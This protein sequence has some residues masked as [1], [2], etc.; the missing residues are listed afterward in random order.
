MGR[1]DRQDINKLRRT[2]S[3]LPSRGEGV[4]EIDTSRRE[5]ARDTRDPNSRPVGY[6]GEHRRS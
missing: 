5:P 4:R 6:R 3:D 2:P 1:E